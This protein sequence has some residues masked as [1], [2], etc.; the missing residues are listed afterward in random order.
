MRADDLQSPHRGSRA[1]SPRPGW[2]G[3][4]GELGLVLVTSPIPAHPS[5]SLLETIVSSFGLVVGLAGRPLVVVADG[6]KEGRLRPK[7][8]EVPAAVAQAYRQGRQALT[9][10]PPQGVPRPGGGPGGGGG[11]GEPVERRQARQAPGAQGLRACGAV[12]GGARTGVGVGV[13]VGTL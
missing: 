13:G 8:G 11:A 10:L 5:T 2:E 3:M 12:Q 9:N 7:R 1:A 6:L 4:A